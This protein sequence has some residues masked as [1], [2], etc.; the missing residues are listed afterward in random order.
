[1]S[2]ATFELRNG[3]RIVI[4]GSVEEVKNLLSFYEGAS[5]EDTEIKTKAQQAVQKKESGKQSTVDLTKIVELVK[6]SPDADVFA[7]KILDR[8][9]SVDRILLPLYIVYKHINNSFGLT[10]GEIGKITK[11]LGV[12]ISQ[13]NVA[14]AFSGSASRYVIG[15]QIR[16]KGIPVRYK[17]SRKGYLYIKSII[18][19]KANAIKK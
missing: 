18:D 7:E 8:S 9:S 13:A 6:N 5:D 17:L 12:P 10:S 1:M 11:D 3:T 19:N 2:K 16:K 14:H 15:D 4:E